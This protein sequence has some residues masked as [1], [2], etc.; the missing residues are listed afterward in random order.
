MVSN[1]PYILAGAVEAGGG[2]YRI[3]MGSAN[4]GKPK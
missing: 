1:E 2:L 4:A 3:P